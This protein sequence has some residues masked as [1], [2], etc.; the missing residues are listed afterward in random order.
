MIKKCW[1]RLQN[2]RKK[3]KTM[4]CETFNVVCRPSVSD[5]LA[6]SSVL[7]GLYGLRP[8]FIKCIIRG[9]AAHLLSFAPL[10]KAHKRVHHVVCCLRLAPRRTLSAILL[11]IR[12]PIGRHI[13]GAVRRHTGRKTI[14]V[15][16]QY[17]M[18]C[19]FYPACR[20]QRIYAH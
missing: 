18:Q 3:T 20:R 1:L 9:D 5:N 16:G 10:L 2:E 6:I 17:S 19:V 14:G 12:T 8:F 4:A 11:L 13:S 7:G 15:V